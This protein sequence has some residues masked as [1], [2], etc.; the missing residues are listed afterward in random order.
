MKFRNLLSIRKWLEHILRMSWTKIIPDKAYLYLDYY[1]ALGKTLHLKH[2]RTF[3]EKMQWLKIYNRNPI[4]ATMADKG[5]VKKYIANI[6]GEQYIIP[7]YGIWTKAE[8]IDF[9][10][11][12][13]K[14]VLKT[15]HDSSGIIICR[16]KSLLNRKETIE[17]LNKRLSRNYFYR[18]REWAYCNVPPRIIAEEYMEDHDNK[19]LLVYKV[20][21]FNGQPRIIQ[22]VQNDK[23]PEETIDYF[24]V[25]W[26][27]LKFHQ[28]Y[29]NSKTIP[30]R[31]AQ[32]SEIL[33]FAQ[34][35]NMGLPFLRTDFYIINNRVYFSEFTFY[36]DAGL[37]NFEPE[38]WDLELGRWINLDCIPQYDQ[39]GC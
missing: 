29:P 4:Y 30:K 10:I 33:T 24:D 14:F 6:L 31:P 7:T 21:N 32:L 34:K 19:S 3:N 25:N 5:A 13:Q 28:N 16:D 12:P 38:F 23:T 37:A 27:R 2:P 15:T 1:Q 36:S 20:F 39:Q 8:D 11:L 18:H 35:L 9:D 17:V 26:N 22:V